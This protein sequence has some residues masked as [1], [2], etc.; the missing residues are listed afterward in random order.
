T[1][2]EEMIST[3]QNLNA[4]YGYLWWLNGHKPTMFPGIPLPFNRWVTP[5]APDEMIAAMGKNGQLLN[6]IPSKNLLMV[7]MGDASDDGQ[8]GLQIQEDI[9]NLLNEILD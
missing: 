4:S 8:V 3:S 6:L 5:N 2:F 1:Y 7:R 9:W